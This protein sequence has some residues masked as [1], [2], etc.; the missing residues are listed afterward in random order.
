MARV[1][2]EVAVGQPVTFT[3]KIDMPPN[4]GSVVAAD[5]D[6][7]GAGA[8]AEAAQ[9]EQYD[10]AERDGDGDACVHAARRL[11]R[12]DPRHV[13]PSRRCSNALCARAESWPRA[14]RRPLGDRL[15]RA[16]GEGDLS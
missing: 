6:F 16:A 12:R 7:E 4:T 14:G 11:L 1:R 10:L 3:A 9:L 5:W 15:S 8:Y 13:A 2:T